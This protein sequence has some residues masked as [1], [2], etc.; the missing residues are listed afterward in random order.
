MWRAIVLCT[1]I[2]LIAAEKATFHNYK[3]FRISP[4]TNTH[5]EL[6][7][8]LT[9]VSDG[10]TFWKEP[11]TVN[12]YV[13]IMVAPHKLPEFYE[14]MAQ[15]KAPH[16]I[17]VENVQTLVDQTTNRSTSTSLD[18]DE[19]YHT[20]WEIYKN[21]D[22]LAKQYPGKVEVVVGGKTYEGRQI[23]GVKVSFKTNNPGIF[24]EGGNHAREW[25]SPAT[26]MYIL[27]QLLTSTDPEIRDLAESHNWYIFPVF[28]PDGYEYTHTTNRMWRKTRELHGLFCR[29]S[30]PNRN[31]GYEWGTGGS[32]SFPCSETYAG[33]APFSDI[34]TKSMSEYI[35]SIS[36]K[37]YAYISF[38]SYSQLLMFPYGYTK[39]HVENYEDLFSFWEEP[40]F[41]GRNVDLMVA[42]HKLPEFYEI[43]A[44]IGI[45]YQVYI[46]DVQ[47]L[48]DQTMP[49]KQSTSFDFNN[50][51]TLEEIY[52]NLD[53]LA[54]QYP[55]KVQVVVGGRTHE[56]RQ[57][58]GVKVS[59]KDNNPGIFIEGGIHARE[60]ISPA[61]VMYILHQLLTSNDQDVRD[62][63]ESHD[64]YIF[65]VF[66]PDGYA[67]T[68]TT[69]RLWR[70]SRKSYGLCVGADLNRNWNYQWVSK[71]LT[72]FPCSEL[73]AGSTPFSEIETKSMSE[74]I[75]SISDKFY[76]YISFHSYSQLLMYPYGYTKEHLDNY[77]DL[78][79]APELA[80]TILKAFTI[81]LSCI[82]TNYA[83]AVVTASYCLLI[84]LFHLEKRQWIL[85]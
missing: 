2:G 81:H 16:Q 5:V 53:D 14:L 29:G 8:Q 49:E 36:D 82:L 61:T 13:D 73:Y 35:K 4:T 50:Y 74:Y 18:F 62:L 41:V 44:R 64:W 58:K 7:R 83:I 69:N 30:D 3:V 20:L 70:K 78:M 51:H 71:G 24:I 15:I 77:K 54:K 57:I 27:H 42:P 38:H 66:N 84:K 34:E 17:Y 1:V 22:D 65:P 55:D 72:G 32:S 43:M 67:Y 33:S 46:E 26:V 31:W 40:S 47:K 68:H 80:W 60:W 45:S 19:G 28:N 76:T 85:S 23:K 12:T 9:E 11:T 25:I 6:L 56:G 39:A 10:L 52:K 75:E 59:F 37:F 79:C 48:I 21:L 63:A